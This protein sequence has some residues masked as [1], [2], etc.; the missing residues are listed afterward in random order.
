MC[1]LCYEHGRWECELLFDDI[2]VVPCH[3]LS[4][5]GV[6][7]IILQR[8]NTYRCAKKLNCGQIYDH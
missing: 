7:F 8:M 6:P 4:M 1:L 5:V 3:N 2:L